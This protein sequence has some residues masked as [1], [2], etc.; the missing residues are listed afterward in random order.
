[1]KG[2][3]KKL[4]YQWSLYLITIPIIIFYLRGVWLN[5]TLSTASLEDVKRVGGLYEGSGNLSYLTSLFA[6]GSP[7]HLF[8]NLT[9]LYALFT[10][11][12]PLY[13]NISILFIYFTSGIIGDILVRNVMPHGAEQ[14]SLGASTAIFGLVAAILIGS[15]MPKSYFNNEHLRFRD[16][17]VSALIMLFAPMLLNEFAN[18]NIG[19]DAHIGGFIVGL[20]ST[21]IVS[22][23][24]I[25]LRPKRNI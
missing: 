25:I 5:G 11:I 15:I 9:A 24:L 18:T 20:F 14:A 23:I 1:M 12:R 10:M 7:M 8:M 19:V 3:F 16:M 4:K 13:N 6:H 21:F 2:F 17:L 22:I